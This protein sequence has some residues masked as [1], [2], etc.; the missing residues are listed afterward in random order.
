LIAQLLTESLL[1]ALFGSLAG[2]V[3]AAGGNRLALAY[4]PANVPRRDP[5]R[6]KASPVLRA[7][8]T[9]AVLALG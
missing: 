1:L 5:L 3:L 7:R 9:P 2:L 6:Q 4:W 8:A